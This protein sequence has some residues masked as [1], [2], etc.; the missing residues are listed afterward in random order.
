MLEMWP[1]KQRSGN[2]KVLGNHCFKNDPVY[3]D[4]RFAVDVSTAGIAVQRF[5]PAWIFFSRFPLSFF[6]QSYT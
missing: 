3:Q 4:E 2:S 6:V 1:A 5:L